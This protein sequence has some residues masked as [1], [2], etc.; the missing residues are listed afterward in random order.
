MF[1]V[2]MGGGGLPQGLSFDAPGS[3]PLATP[4]TFYVGAEA[5]G[6]VLALWDASTQ[7]WIKI[8]ASDGLIV[9]GPTSVTFDGMSFSASSMVLYPPN[10]VSGLVISQASGAAF[11]AIAVMVNG[12]PQPTFRI[13]ENG[14]MMVQKNSA[15]T[16]AEVFENGLCI[17]F[18]ST[19][20]SPK[21]MVKAKQA[22]GTVV[23]GNIALS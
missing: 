22:N 7:A 15:P 1:R 10:T 17:W 21:L 8:Y 9:E 18:D 5:N 16:N 13:N 4:N 6:G 2:R 11:D 23:T 12:V 19:N 20:G 3:G 14:Y